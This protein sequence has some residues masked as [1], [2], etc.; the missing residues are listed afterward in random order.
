MV[1]HMLELCMSCFTFS[2]N[3]DFDLQFLVSFCFFFW[4][5]SIFLCARLWRLLAFY[6]TIL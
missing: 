4:Q 5:F 3:F 1:V 2:F 6:L